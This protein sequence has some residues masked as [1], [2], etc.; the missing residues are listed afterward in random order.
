MSADADAIKTQALRSMDMVIQG[1]QT[2][3]WGI[4]S[5]YIEHPVVAASIVE[6]HLRLFLNALHIYHNDEVC[7]EYAQRI[8]ELA[9]P[10]A[11]GA[12]EVDEET[13]YESLT[14]PLLEQ[15]G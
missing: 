15:L 13:M 5:N 4:T 6:G 12:V 9:A 14:P 11:A 8:I 3:M 10:F 1:L 2:G 7:A